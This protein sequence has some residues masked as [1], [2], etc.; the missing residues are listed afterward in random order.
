[1][2]KIIIYDATCKFCTRFTSWSEASNP[3]LKAIPVRSKE[4]RMHL[5]NANVHFINLQ[6]IYFISDGKAYV[7]S[8]AIFQIM[9]LMPLPW[10]LLSGFEIFPLS[11]TDYLYNLFAKYRYRL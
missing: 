3:I 4:A 6:T 11:L 8:K 5:R 10:R 7:K 9:R 2:E 1:M